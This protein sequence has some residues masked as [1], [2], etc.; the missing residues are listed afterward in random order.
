MLNS[1]VKFLRLTQNIPYL[2]DTSVKLITA[3]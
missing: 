3:L 2:F 1:R